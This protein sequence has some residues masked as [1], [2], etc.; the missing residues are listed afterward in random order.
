ME[1]VIFLRPMGISVKNVEVWEFS[2][3]Y[4]NKSSTPEYGQ[5]GII[6][7]LNA[8]NGSGKHKLHRIDWSS[9]KQ[10]SVIHSSYGAKILACSDG[11]D[12]GMYVKQAV[13]SIIASTRTKHVLNIDSRELF[14]TISTLNYGKEYCIR[15]TVDRIRDRFESTDIN[16]LRCVPAG[17]NLPDILT[18]KSPKIQEVLRGFAITGY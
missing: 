15:Q 11:N 9:S 8:N 6:I 3:V 18:N 13:K 12:R 17:Q 2:D 1:L 10:R 7:G 5:N 4:L 14:D 16:D